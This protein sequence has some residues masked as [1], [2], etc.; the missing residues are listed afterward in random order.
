M[1]YVRPLR[2]ARFGLFAYIVSVGTAMTLPS[3]STPA[4]LATTAASPSPQFPIRITLCAAGL[5][6]SSTR[7]RFD[8]GPSFDFDAM[9]RFNVGLTAALVGLQ[10]QDEARSDGLPSGL[11]FWPPNGQADTAA[12][13][14]KR[15]PQNPNRLEGSA[16]VS[17]RGR[18]ETARAR[19]RGGQDPGGWAAKPVLQPSAE[20]RCRPGCCVTGTIVRPASRGSIDVPGA[21]MYENCIDTKTPHFI[22][23]R[24]ERRQQVLVQQLPRPGKINSDKQLV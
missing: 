4:S 22:T 15:A 18:R 13:G 8:A 10:M 5:P 7:G 2:F 19:A 9:V 14:G 11:G 23:G 16:A 1:V 21:G 12:R 3:T 6:S 20:S 24:R 17:A